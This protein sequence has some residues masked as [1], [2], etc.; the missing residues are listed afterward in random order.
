MKY[1][2]TVSSADLVPILD[3]Q[4]AGR[5]E[6][7]VQTQRKL[8]LRQRSEKPWA[9]ANPRIKSPFALRLKEEYHLK[10][11]Y[12]VTKIP[13]TS[14]QKLALQG[15]EEFVDRMLAEHDKD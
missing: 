2:L 15:V 5:T 14:M 7:P 6:N 4:P 11:Q 10:L 12:L 9:S 13:N 1:A 8:D 3:E